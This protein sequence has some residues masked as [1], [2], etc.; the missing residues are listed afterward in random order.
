VDHSSTEPPSCP[1]EFIPETGH[2]SRACICAA[3]HDP[4]GQTTGDGWP[5]VICLAAWKIARWYM[6]RVLC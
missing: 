5:L 3:F 1:D 4:K 2:L 6:S